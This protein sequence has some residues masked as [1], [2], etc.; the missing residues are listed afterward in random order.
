MSTLIT[1]RK[2]RSLC[3][4]IGL[5]AGLICTIAP[6]V[7]GQGILSST[8]IH[9]FVFYAGIGIILSYNGKQTL[10]L[11]SIAILLSLILTFVG[12]WLTGNVTGL[13]LSNP[14]LLFTLG[15]YTAICLLQSYHQ[16]NYSYPS[17]DT[18]FSNACNNFVLLM[19]SF[20]FSI[21]VYLVLLVLGGAFA[22]IGITFFKTLF[23]EASFARFFFPL[24]FAAGLYFNVQWQS[25]LSFF[26]TVVLGFFKF[27]LPVLMVVGWLYVLALFYQF[28]TGYG[29]SSSRYY[30]IASQLIGFA[31]LSVVALSAVYQT[32][33]ETFSDAYKKM[34]TAL[35]ALLPL[36]VITS[37][38]LLLCYAAEPVI[39]KQSISLL[40]IALLLL[41]YTL[42]YLYGIMQ[43]K[44]AWLSSLK[45]GNLVLAWVLIGCMLLVNVPALYSGLP[46]PTKV[47]Q[48][49]R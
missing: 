16:K 23:M 14:N 37:C 29:F 13:V 5:L 20:L 32:G 35:V 11:V 15:A 7:L 45:K 2:P 38:V 34:I 48:Q 42:V 40:V 31:G 47:H 12:R 24:F 3:L 21:L 22:L 26:K 27:F 1:E 44:G 49:Q 6:L 33:K 30:Y 9:L 10:P 36:V 17:Y 39:N 19:S 4:G 43:T 46:S 41:S 8:A 28:I 25:V 18:F